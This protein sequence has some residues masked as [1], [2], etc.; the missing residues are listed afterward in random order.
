MLQMHQNLICRA[1]P[2][3]KSPKRFGTV[4]AALGNIVACVVSPHSPTL[5]KRAHTEIGRLVLAWQPFVM[6]LPLMTTAK[7]EIR[8]VISFLNA[9]GNTPI[10]IHHQLTEVY[11]E[12]CMDIKNIRKWCRE[13]AFDRTEIHDENEAEGHN[14][15][16][17]LS[18]RLRKPC[19]K[20]GESLWMISAFRFL[21]F[22]EAQFFG[23]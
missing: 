6:E 11:S 13:F 20:N 2:I 4:C 12:M 10:E 7:C 8:S 17:R 18:R 3:V 23:F 16:T 19:L 9:K 1:I 22:F 14:L 15:A 5:S 21:R